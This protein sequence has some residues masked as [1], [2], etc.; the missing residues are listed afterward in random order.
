MRK[1]P[2]TK[3]DIQALAASIAAFGVVQYPVVEPEN[4][5]RGNTNK[6]LA[7]IDRVTAASGN[8]ADI[9]SFGEIQ[10]PATHPTPIPVAVLVAAAI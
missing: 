8:G 3:A 4:G 1:I 9:Q 5:P 2:H 10:P 7:A 6:V